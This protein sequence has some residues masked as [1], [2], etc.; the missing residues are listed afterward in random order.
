MSEWL[1]IESA[2]KDGTLIILARDERVTVGQWQDPETDGAGWDGDDYEAY[3]H[4]WDGGF[5]NDPEYCASH[6]MPLPDP[7]HPP[8]E[9]GMSNQDSFEGANSRGDVAR[10]KREYAELFNPMSK[11]RKAKAQRGKAKDVKRKRR[12]P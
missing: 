9:R 3:W 7:P 11:H 6:W 4:S 8:G 5:L 1:P 10:Q 2:P 12:K